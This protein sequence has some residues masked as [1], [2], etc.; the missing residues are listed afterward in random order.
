MLAIASMV[1]FLL[2]RRRDLA[3]VEDYKKIQD[4]HNKEIEQIQAARDEERKRL[5]A[6]KIQLQQT[7]DAIQKQYDERS[8]ELDAKKKEEIESII[9]EHGHEP[10]VLARKL[11]E[12]T[13]FVVIQPEDS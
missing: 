7:L 1:A 2:F 10:D 5:E 3:F 6:N 4:A 11:A 12:A 8:R 9:N 13:G